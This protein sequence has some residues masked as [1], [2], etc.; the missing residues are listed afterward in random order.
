LLHSENKTSHF[1]FSTLFLLRY[2]KGTSEIS[3]ESILIMIF[4]EQHLLGLILT[5]SYKNCRVYLFTQITLHQVFSSYFLTPFCSIFFLSFKIWSQKKTE[6][7]NFLH[8]YICCLHRNF[9]LFTANF[10][11][12]FS[13]LTGSFLHQFLV[14]QTYKF[15]CKKKQKFALKI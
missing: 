10:Y 7:A 5:H 1:R 12:K 3:R 2:L 11:A 14:Y 13:F 9:C 6:N 4:Y 15:W 8:Q